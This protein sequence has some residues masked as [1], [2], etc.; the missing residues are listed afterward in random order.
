MKSL[1]S[2]KKPGML[3][4][5]DVWCDGTVEYSTE[6][7]SATLYKYFNIDICSIKMA[8]EVMRMS[9]STKLGRG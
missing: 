7:Q 2:T 5:D 9:V 3:T 4:G 6:V 1:P 8:V